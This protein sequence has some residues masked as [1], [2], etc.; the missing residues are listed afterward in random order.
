MQTVAAESTVKV[1][2]HSLTPAEAAAGVPP[3]Q[4]F[5]DAAGAAADPTTVRIFLGDP[6]G[7]VRSFSW[8]TTQTGDAGA[9]TRQEVGRFYVEWTPDA[10][11]DGVWAWALVGLGQPTPT[12]SLADQDVFY[13]KRPIIDRLA[14]AL[15]A[16]VRA[17]G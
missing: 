3:R 15:A 13:C 10:D 8:P 7:T 17:A 4:P 6:A 11:E 14:A 16:V 1:G 12:A 9:V 2:N 5:V